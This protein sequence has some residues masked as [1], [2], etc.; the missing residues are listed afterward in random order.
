MNGKPFKF[1]LIE[2]IADR[3]KV[4]KSTAA[5]RFVDIGNHP[6]MVVFAVDGKIRW[7]NCSEDF[8][9]WRLRYGNGKG[10]RV[11]EYTVMGTY[12]YEN[13][14]SDCRSEE[15]VYAKDC[16]YT[17]SEDDNNREFKEWCIDFK[18]C[19]LSVFWEE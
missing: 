1:Q 11:P 4:S 19:A 13:E 5:L 8:P 9:F 7:V 17:R 15:T 16:F 18:N 10:D 14:N 2:A 3:Y 6:I 12:F